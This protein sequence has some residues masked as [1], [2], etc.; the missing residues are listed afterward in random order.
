MKTKLDNWSGLYTS[1]ESNSAAF[2]GKPPSKYMLLLISLVYS[3]VLKT[4][5]LERL[6]NSAILLELSRYLVLEFCPAGNVYKGCWESSSK[7]LKEMPN[8]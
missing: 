2:A 8:D 6:F 4:E 7:R 5:A 1:S 3:K